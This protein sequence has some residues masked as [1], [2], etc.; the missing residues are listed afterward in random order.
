MLLALLAL[1]WLLGI[2]AAAFTNADPAASLAASGLLGVISFTLRP[3]ASTLAYIAAGSVLIFAAG[4]R[5]DA[6]TR[7]ESPVARFNGGDVI[8]LRAIV[9]DEPQEQ[10]SSWLVRLDVRESRDDR[11]WREDSGGVLMRAPLFPEYRYG[12]LLEISGKL[13]SPPVFEEFDYRGYLFRQGIDSMVAYPRVRVVAHD[14]GSIV[15]TRLTQ[16]RSSLTDAIDRVL[17]EPEAA[18]AAGILLGTRSE[19]P[20]DLTED[21]QATGTSHL[22]AVSGQNVVLVAA[23]VM[24][25]LT[26]VVGRRPAAWTAIA[27][28]VVYAALVGAQ[29]SVVRAAVMGMLFVTAIALGRRN[30][31]SVALAIAAAAMTAHDPHIVHDVSFQLSF[32]ATLGLIL[33]S[34]PITATIEN[35]LSRAPAISGFA[36]TRSLVDV[37]AM[38]VAATAFTL[39][40]IAINFERVSLVA[41]IANLLAVPAFIAV[42]G[43]SALTIVVA[44]VVPGDASFMAWVA[45]PPAAYMISVIRLLAGLPMASVE[46]R[47]VNVGHAIAYYSVLAAMVLWISR[48]PIARIERT[49]PAPSV[50]VS[51]MVP[52]IATGGVLCLASALLWLAAS[53]SDAD[54]LS[55]SFLDVGQG[56]AILIE[57]PEGH[58][59][60][61]DGGPSGEVLTS[62]L[63]R[64]L[65]FH[66]RRIDMMVL[67][68]PQ[69]DHLGGLPSVLDLYSVRNVLTNSVEGETAAYAAWSESIAAH[70]IAPMAAKRGQTIDL[71][72]GA[73][74]SIIGPSHI[75]S[76]DIND[77]SLVLRV[78]MGDASFLLTADITEESE[79]ALLK[80]G[81]DIKSTVLKVAHHG[82]RTSTTPAFLSR[83]DP[84]VGV[85]SVGAGNPYGHPSP[86]VLQRLEEDQLLRTDES[87]DVT[88]ETDGER[89]WFRTQHASPLPASVR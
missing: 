42:A 88:I 4:W 26:W 35:L 34:S 2:A 9:S 27:G 74:L 20:R 61:V 50:G 80:T 24:G 65:P 36:L 89:I 19:L 75:D 54:R 15:K 40:I 76:A 85:I 25:V 73:V 82:S 44:S 49:P 31:A 56:D 29:P 62:A 16:V 10:G 69:Q 14:Q 67:T 63:G 71:G 79:V 77:S 38:S 33:L 18:L 46:L 32:A 7:G 57:G 64:R 59:I 12:D 70:G 47:D 23:I 84:A 21:M 11:G 68:H 41:P 48:R 78:A 6:T 58:R 83:A 87:G 66:D 86:E 60:L 28:I 5:Y 45:W 17:P 3:R 81:T 13:E 39:P 22:V 53:S 1:A 55:V 72:G 37:A 30:T 43:S 52:V 8:S 51:R